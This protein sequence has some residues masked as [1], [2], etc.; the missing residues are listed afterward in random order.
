MTRAAGEC[1]AGGLLISGAL[2]IRF[3]LVDPRCEYCPSPS[4]GKGP[5]SGN[6]SDGV[7]RGG[8]STLLGPEETDTGFCS[9]VGCLQ[10]AFERASP[11]WWGGFGRTGRSGLHT[12]SA[13]LASGF[14][15]AGGLGGLV[16]VWVGVR[17]CFENCI[18]NASI[19]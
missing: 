8:W 15:G 9:G 10:V 16:V 7:G 11:G 6:P 3:F 4:F 14:S 2:A 12:A 18:V 13:L 17:S 19:L 5:G 1:S